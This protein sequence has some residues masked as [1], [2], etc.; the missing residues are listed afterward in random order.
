MEL[1]VQEFENDVNSYDGQ[2]RKRLYYCLYLFENDV[3]SYDG[4]T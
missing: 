2:T 4:Q 3:N 1:G